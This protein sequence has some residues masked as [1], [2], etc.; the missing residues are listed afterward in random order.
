LQ[1]ACNDWE[2]GMD[3]PLPPILI[4]H[5]FLLRR[6][7]SA[8]GLVPVGAYMVVHLATNASV[9][10]GPG[11]FQQ[12]VYSIHSLGRLLP[13]VEWGF[14][15]IPILFHAIMGVAIVA[16]MKPNTAHYRY[17]G[18]YRYSLQRWTGMIAF[19]FIVW[20]VFHMHGWFHGEW[21]VEH[22]ARPYGGGRFRPYN[23]A[24]SAGL[25]LQDS[26]V[27]VLYA[28]GLLSCVF[29]LANGIW[30]A[31]ITWGVWTSPRAQSRALSLCGVF[32]I[33]LALVGLGALGGMRAVG[34]GDGL[35]QAREVESTQYQHRI[36]AGQIFPD[37]HKRATD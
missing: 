36:E 16:G 13:V 6:L 20:H 9:L 24:S 5:E 7:H 26:I 35:R 28:I 10:N 12:N 3:Q 33:L 18:N 37:D 19:A 1:I 17:G 8:S 15:F 34:Q 4:R 32:G 22:V 14:I 2:P 29:H 27:L 30:T 21:W 25:A 31:G 11:T 23:A